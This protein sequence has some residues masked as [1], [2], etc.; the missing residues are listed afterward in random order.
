MSYFICISKVGEMMSQQLN[1]P[2][3][4][5]ELRE[6]LDCLYE[7]TKRQITNGDIPRFKGLFEVASCETCIISAIH[8]I[9][10]NKGSKTPGSDNVVIQDILSQ[11]L[12]VVIQFIQT[13]MNNYKPKEIRR[14]Y[15]P[16]PG[17]SEKRP[18]GIPAIVDRII[19]ECIRLTIEPI[20]EA[21]FFKHSYG[22]RPMRD[23]KQAIE[24]AIHLCNRT[25]N[26]WVIE[27]DIQGF[28]DNVN[29]RILL[30]QLWHMGIRDRRI[31][32][33][34]KEMLKAGIM[35]EIKR[36]E[37][38]TPQGGIISP[39]LANV[40]LHK[41][42]QWIAREWEE[43]TLR[44]GTTS[45]ISRF[46]SLRNY[47][48]ITKPAFFI[49]YADDWILFTSSKDNAEKWKY[50]I[51]KYLKENLKLEL[52]KEKTLITNIRKKSLKFLGFKV[53]KIPK[54]K[55]YVGYSYPDKDK[56]K[57]KFN[58]ISK[59]IRKLKYCTDTEWLIHDI[60]KVNSK[61]RGVINYYNSSAGINLIM[62]KF[63]ENL[64][65]TSYKALKKYGGQWI[66]ANQCKNLISFYPERMEQVPAVRYRNEWIGII[67]LG[68]ATWVKYPKKNQNETPY[69]KIG[70][71]LYYIRSKRRPLSART[72]ALLND[73]YL[74]LI[75]AGHK[76]KIYN[77]EYFMNRCYAFNRDK[78]K[79]TICK[80]ELTGYADTH[81]HHIDNK[82]PLNLI[83]KV[84]NLATICIPCHKLIHAK[85]L[86]DKVLQLNQHSFKKLLKYRETLIGKAN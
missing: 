86:Q 64:K 60:N 65:Y 49:R 56:L 59:E 85:D 81:T 17:K 23:A 46:S 19:Q 42:D 31:L 75:L 1:L 41:L 24:R 34:I 22:F 16:K 73:E 77:F 13:S 45:S 10:A 7:Q 33:I 25:N 84:Q 36:N 80:I 55:G 30:K 8:K 52:S 32:M 27:G 40:Y 35:N 5:R 68:F 26:N 43:K 15:I 50:R 37:L 67:S 51:S 62:R 69:S 66:P 58:E 2:E 3:N 9:K 74:A 47:S 12:K 38:G 14:V 61:I 79:C 83:N 71:E 63:R 57:L 11:D 53:K 72:E 48:T 78:G 6:T 39:L 4:E 54:G 76:P 82:L 20:L 29:H 44:N 70:R 18:L 28:F 21:Q